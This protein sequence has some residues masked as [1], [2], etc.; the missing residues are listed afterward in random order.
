MRQRKRL[1]LLERNWNVRKPGG[2]PQPLISDSLNSTLRTA[3]ASP[4]CRTPR[5]IP[6]QS[7]QLSDCRQSASEPRA[8]PFGC[9]IGNK[10]NHSYQEPSKASIRK[11]QRQCCIRSE[12]AALAVTTE[13]HDDHAVMCVE[14]FVYVLVESEASSQASGALRHRWARHVKNSKRQ[15]IGFAE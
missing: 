15:H 3:S 7:F 11:H 14:M 2:S 6:A 5:S 13:R 8:S 4:R 1:D 10:L 9:R 12:H